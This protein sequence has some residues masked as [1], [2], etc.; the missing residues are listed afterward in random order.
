MPTPSFSVA[1]IG[2]SEAKPRSVAHS[3]VLNLLEMPL[4]R[5][6]DF[7]SWILLWCHPQS[8]TQLVGLYAE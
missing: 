6:A 1:E 5:Q 3:D 4:L 8:L 7:R 2:A